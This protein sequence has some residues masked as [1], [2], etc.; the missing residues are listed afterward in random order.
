MTLASQISLKPDNGAEFDPDAG[1]GNVTVVEVFG[2]KKVVG[3][4]IQAPLPA[5]PGCLRVGEGVGPVRQDLTRAFPSGK[6]LV[7]AHPVYPAP[8]QI[9]RQPLQDND[10]GL[11][12]NLVAEVFKGVI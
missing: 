10:V 4:Q 12:H 9:E 7:R 5:I 3:F 6:V 2:I 1:L 8:R 11:E